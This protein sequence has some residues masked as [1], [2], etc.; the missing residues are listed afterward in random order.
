MSFDSVM[1][2]YVIIVMASVKINLNLGALTAAATNV[3]TLG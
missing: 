3:R 1:P 2:V